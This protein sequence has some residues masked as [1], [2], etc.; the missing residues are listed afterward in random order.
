MQYFA[1]IDIGSTAIKIVIIDESGDIVGQKVSG[2]GSM[3]Y[4]YAKES[5]GQLV[6]DIGISMDDIAYIVSTGYGRKLFKE[7]DETIS[8]ITANAVGARKAGEKF[9]TIRT[10]INIGGQDS[11]AIGLDDEGNVVNF[12]MNDRCAAGTGKFLDVAAA[13]LE[14]DVE[15]LGE[16]HFRAD[17]TPLAINSTC[18]VFAESEIIGL[19]GNEHS[20]EDIVAGIHF[21]IAKRIIRLAK[22]VGLNDIIYFDGG[23]ALNAGLVAAIEDELGRE[24]AIPDYPQITTALGAAILA[25]EGHYFES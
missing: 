12:A 16:L 5:L 6:K 1:G 19:L 10:I 25:K 15:E 18:A 13:K 11:K 22:R 23:P 9:G 24:I 21:S 4:K 20:R 8:E 7:A 3:F 17:G 2:S 14:I